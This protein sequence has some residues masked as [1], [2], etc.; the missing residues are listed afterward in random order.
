MLYLA[1]VLGAVALV[2]A[3]SA[4]KIASGLGA[5]LEQA[6][7]AARRADSNAADHD[8]RARRLEQ[9]VKLLASGGRVDPEMV[10][11]GRLF[12][13]IDADQARRLLEDD[14]GVAVVDVRSDQEVA[15]GHIK[16]AS[17]IPLDQLEQR[18]REVPKKGRVLVFCAVG[19]RSAAAC[20]Y[21][22][23]RGWTNVTN[24]VGGMS[25]WKGPVEMGTPQRPD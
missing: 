3:V 6:E 5:R 8:A 11:E 22:T 20:D 17:W 2:T 21:L 15:G 19:G 9:F 18:Y 23:G 10:E 4:F 1:I 7:A 24:V 12:D 14:A 25:A 13:E 16:G